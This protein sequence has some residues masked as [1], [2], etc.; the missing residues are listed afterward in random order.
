[1]PREQRRE[2]DESEL[3]ELEKLIP[4]DLPEDYDYE[5]DFHEEYMESG[6]QWMG[7]D[8]LEDMADILMRYDDERNFFNED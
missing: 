5:D 3:E 6:P 2:L 8:S 7:P 4:P 1:M